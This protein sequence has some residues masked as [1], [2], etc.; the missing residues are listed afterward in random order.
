MTGDE[1]QHLYERL[2][3]RVEAVEQELRTLRDGPVR[4]LEE[5]RKMVQ[6]ALLTVFATITYVSAEGWD[7]IRRIFI[8]Q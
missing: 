8:R 1:H 5:F 7:L 2:E 3:R 6:V 4:K